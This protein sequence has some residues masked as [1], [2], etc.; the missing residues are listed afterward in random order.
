MAQ[1]VPLDPH[2]RAENPPSNTANDDGTLQLCS[3]VAYRR[4]GIVNVVF[5]GSPGAGDRKW[6][7]ID[8][9]VMG[10]TGLITRAA[11]ERF[12]AKSRPAAIVMTHGHFD[13]VGALEEISDLEG[14]WHSDWHPLDGVLENLGWFGKRFRPD[15]RECTVVSHGTAAAHRHRSGENTSSLGASFPKHRQHGRRETPVSCLMR[16][17]RAKGPVASLTTMPLYGVVS[18]AMIY[19]D[20]PIV[21]YFRRIDEQRIMGAMTVSGDDRI[22]FFELERVDEPLQRHASN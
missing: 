16:G 21:D 1:Q 15:M 2:G 5:F 17:L 12:G 7:L 13:H 8:A 3:D 14:A 19:D 11:E 10:T 4:L 22:Y 20:Q 18:A 6:V 9:G